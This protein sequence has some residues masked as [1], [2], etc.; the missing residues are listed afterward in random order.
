L[1]IAR[2]QCHAGVADQVDRLLAA[3][4]WCAHAEKMQGVR[5]VRLDVEDLPI[6]LLGLF[7]PPGAVQ[8]RGLL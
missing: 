2:A 7:Q 4:R 1:T 5:V 3:P 6:K 8:R